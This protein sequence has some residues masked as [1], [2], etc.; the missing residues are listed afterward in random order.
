MRKFKFDEVEKKLIKEI[1]EAGFKDYEDPDLFVIKEKIH[2]KLYKNFLIVN[3]SEFQ[4]L[5]SFVQNWLT[6]NEDL[7]LEINKKFY[8]KDPNQYLYFDQNYEIIINRIDTLFSI[9]EKIIKEKQFLYKT[10][11]LNIDKI[12]YANNFYVSLSDNK[13][14]KIAI[15]NKNEVLEWELCI[16]QIFEEKSFVKSSKIELLNL[17]NNY[18]KSVSREEVSMIFEN[19]TPRKSEFNIQFLKNILSK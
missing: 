1:L 19:Y 14:Y 9:I 18:N 13:P 11:F 5:N 10:I 17:K 8:G 6:Q 15:I 16:N 2:K 3:T 12:R 4:L 7:I